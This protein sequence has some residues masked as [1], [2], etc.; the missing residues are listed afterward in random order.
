MSAT[1]SLTPK[2][3]AA[4]VSIA[5]VSAYLVKRLVEPS[6][7]CLPPGP[8]SFPLI[9]NLLSMPR[10]L[11]HVAYAQMS[12]DLKSNTFIYNQSEQALTLSG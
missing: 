7:R 8:K 9:G 3:V 1:S 4:A 5:A 10:S 2:Q 12:Q 6:R 11:E